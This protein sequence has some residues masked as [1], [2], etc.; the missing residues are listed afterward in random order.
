[1]LLSWLRCLAPAVAG[2]CPRN[3]IA[4]CRAFPAVEQLARAH[5]PNG[6]LKRTVLAGFSQGGALST[7]IA[8]T[9]EIEY[10]ALVVLSAY[11]PLSS[12]ITEVRRSSLP[13][14]AMK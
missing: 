14:P 13:P 12:R 10:G 5:A 11:M 9:S 2:I 7:Y 1:M 8:L 6:D 3:G 4:D